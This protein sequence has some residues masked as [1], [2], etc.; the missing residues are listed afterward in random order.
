MS[1]DCK[2]WC[3]DKQQII[4]KLTNNIKN[5]ENDEHIQ[6]AA[7]AQRL[8]MIDCERRNHDATRNGTP[9]EP[10][11]THRCGG[12]RKKYIG[13]T[14]NFKSSTRRRIHRTRTKTVRQRRRR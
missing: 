1:I 12:K 2:A 10:L 11:D 7:I 3:D 4:N 5:N 9:V 6:Q 13:K 8:C 14:K